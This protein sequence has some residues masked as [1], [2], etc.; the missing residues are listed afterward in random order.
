MKLQKIQFPL[1][2]V[3][4]SHPCKGSRECWLRGED[5]TRAQDR[6]EGGC[7]P[8]VTSSVSH[9]TTRVSKWCIEKL[10]T[11]DQCFM[12]NHSV[13]QICCHLSDNWWQWK[14]LEFFK[15]SC[16]W[17]WCLW[18]KLKTV[19]LHQKVRAG[20]ISPSAAQPQTHFT[21]H[22]LR[23]RLQQQQQMCRARRLVEDWR[24]SGCTGS[25]GSRAPQ[26]AKG[27]RERNTNKKNTNWHFA[28]SRY[29]V[30][31]QR[32]LGVALWLRERKLLGVV[33][34]G[35]CPCSGCC[36]PVLRVLFP[37]WAGW[38]G[39]GQGGVIRDTRI[40]GTGA[41]GIE[42]RM[43]GCS[44]LLLIASHQK[45][46]GRWRRTPSH[47]YFCLILSSWWSRLDCKLDF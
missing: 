12:L 45:P 16:Q 1:L 44:R 13:S 34:Y 29:V 14:A 36:C 2:F 5:S 21:S 22:L 4:T 20:L 7:F 47:N 37:S 10:P 9:N 40:R 19:Y 28:E 27:S 6:R 11:I 18:H 30:R 43:W 3:L 35:W 8:P 32:D 24:W 33:F 23:R 42:I 17:I 38:A 25:P 26:P 15:G 41:S 39:G 46:S 31:T